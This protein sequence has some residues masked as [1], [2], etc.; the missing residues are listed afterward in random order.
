M[1]MACGHGLACK[2]HSPGM[3]VCKCVDTLPVDEL[4]CRCDACG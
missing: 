4:V 3:D 1:C 2:K